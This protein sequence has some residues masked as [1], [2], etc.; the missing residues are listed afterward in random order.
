MPTKLNKETYEKMILEDIEW[1]ENI[2]GN[3]LEKRHIV[4][5]LQQSIKDYEGFTYRKETLKENNMYI[6]YEYDK[7]KNP[8][9]TPCPKEKLTGNKNL[10][11][12]GSFMCQMCKNYNGSDFH[13][14]N[15][16]G[17]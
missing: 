2:P 1:L 16:K 10:I 7:N 6:K 4:I 14:V 12:V 8:Y 15:C 13:E 17:E 3:S 9:T 5:V 11:M